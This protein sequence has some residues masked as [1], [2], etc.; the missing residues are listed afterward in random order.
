MKERLRI[1]ALMGLASGG[2]EFLLRVDP[3]LG[4]GFFEHL[5]WALGALLAGL[6]VALPMAGVGYLVRHVP[7]VGPRRDGL[8]LGALLAVHAVLF[9]RFEVALNEP[10]S[11]PRL[12]V[13][14]IGMGVGCMIMGL[15]AARWIGKGLKFAVLAGAIGFW[16]AFIRGLPPG[17][18]AE[19]EGPNLLIVTWDTTRPD[20]LGAYGGPAYTDTLSRLASGG[21]RFDQAVATAPLTE[22][23]HLSLLTGLNTTTTGV[24]SNGTPLGQQPLMLQHRLSDEGFRTGAVVSGFPLHSRYGWDQGWDV[25]DDDFGAVAGVHQL[26]LGRLLEN[27]FLPGNTLRERPGDRAVKRAKSFLKRSEG[28]RWFLWLHLFDPHAPY[29]QSDLEGAPRDGEALDL[30]GYWPPPHRSITSAEWL[31]D[32]YDDELEHTDV[33]T[34]DVLGWLVEHDLYDNTIIVMTAD[35]GESLTEHGTLFDHGDDLYDPSLRV[36]LIIRGPGITPGVVPCQV[37]GADLVPTLV[38]LLDLT[39]MNTDG[40]SLVPVLQGETCDDHRV[41]STTMGARFVENPPLDLSLRDP[42]TKYIRHGEGPPELYD[43][44]DDPGELDDLAHRDDLVTYWNEV[45]DAELQDR[46]VE[47]KPPAMDTE[48]LRMLMELGYLEDPEE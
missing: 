25:Y 9:Y 1:A 22:P 43:L 26:S 20:R 14:L 11:D 47:L 12:L 7:Y 27:V 6:L 40:Q 19:T 31:T 29:E 4:F 34:G 8:P 28:G 21:V 32:A 13:I 38:E 33:L 39:E 18:S 2:M 10:M 37:S 30:P 48:S 5:L 23:S 24:V 35:H 16:F 42:T 36:P 45:L 46:V 44:L 3:R 17:P 41:I 15:T